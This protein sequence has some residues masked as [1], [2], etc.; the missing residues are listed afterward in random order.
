MI[1]S[2]RIFLKIS[3]FNDPFI[4]KLYA[5]L[6][7]K[8]FRQLRLRSV[9]KPQIITLHES[10]VARDACL[11]V[12]SIIVWRGKPASSEAIAPVSMSWSALSTSTHRDYKRRTFSY[13]TF[14]DSWLLIERATTRRDVS[15]RIFSYRILRA[16]SLGKP[17]HVSR[18]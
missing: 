4:E 5:R 11:V 2:W 10:F 16:F 8:D 17:V 13:G 12:K 7:S 15:P 9:Q 14:S 18:R 3:S 6:F 1:S